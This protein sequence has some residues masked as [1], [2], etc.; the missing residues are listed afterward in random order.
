LM[1]VRPTVA[2]YPSAK[3]LAPESPSCRLHAD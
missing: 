3:W 1:T 2:R